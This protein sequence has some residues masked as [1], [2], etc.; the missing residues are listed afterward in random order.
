[1][2]GPPDSGAFPYHLAL[3]QATTGKL[4]TQGLVYDGERYGLVLH[5]DSA[6]LSPWLE[7]RWV[8]VFGIDSRGKSVLLFPASGAG[9]VFNRLP[10]QPGP[11]GQWPTEL[12]L[13][14]ESLFHI[15]APF[16]MDT[17]VLLTSDEALPLDA[18]EWDGVREGASRGVGGSPLA[19]LLLGNSVGTRSPAA[20]VSPNWSIE[21]LSILSAPKR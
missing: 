7:R 16:G 4:L 14:R 1:M 6:Q 5:A 11:T 17:Y 18:F 15:S 21:R 20:D 2:E 13:G 12:R 9:N 8:Y 19:S 3:R 10:Y